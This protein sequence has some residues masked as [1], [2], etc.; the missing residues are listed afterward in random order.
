MI[1]G[2][3][4]FLE[5]GLKVYIFTQADQERIMTHTRPSMPHSLEKADIESIKET[6]E[7]TEEQERKVERWLENFQ[8][9]E[10]ERAKSDPVN[11]RRQQQ[12]A[13]NLALLLV[14]APVFL[15]HWRMV[16]KENE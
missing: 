16:K 4:N 5:M 7:L 14:G 2:A 10:E 9:W 11:S 3:V 8:R 12:A 1:V 15:Y 13:R 6:G